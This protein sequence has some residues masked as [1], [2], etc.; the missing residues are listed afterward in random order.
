M[1]NPTHT[2]AVRRA[3]YLHLR[4][5]MRQVTEDLQS[6]EQYSR[7]GLDFASAGCQF[8]TTAFEFSALQ[9]GGHL[10]NQLR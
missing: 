2:L 6:M 9:V 4:Q 10:A 8:D 5:C 7:R 1:T 3:A